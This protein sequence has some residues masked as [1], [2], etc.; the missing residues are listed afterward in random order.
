MALGEASAPAS[1]AIVWH[2]CGSRIAALGRDA[3]EGRVQHTPSWTQCGALMAL[4][5]EGC[6]NRPKHAGGAQ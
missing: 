5:E 4:V 3:L 1:P 6:L 2:H